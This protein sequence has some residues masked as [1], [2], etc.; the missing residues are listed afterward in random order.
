MKEIQ[1]EVISSTSNDMSFGHIALPTFTEAVQSLILA[2]M[3]AYFK[4]D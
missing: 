1:Y 3:T 2:Y 4:E